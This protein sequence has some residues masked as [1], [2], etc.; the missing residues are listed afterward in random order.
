MIRP[1]N[2]A[3]VVF[4]DAGDGDL[5][6]APSRRAFF[7]SVLGIPA[8]WATVK[9]VHG[10]VIERA[11]SPG[12]IGE[13]DGIWTTKANLPVAVFTA[14]CL[15]VVLAAEGAKGVAHAGWRGAAQDVV[16]ALFEEMAAAGFRPTSAAI[17]PGIGPCCFEV[18]DEVSARFPDSQ[19]STTW[20]TQSVDL[21]RHITAGLG[22]DDVWSAGLCTM[23]DPGWFSHRRD[24]TKSRMAAVAWI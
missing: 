6:G 18:G 3:G 7:S 20:G 15:G 4:S 19:S 14:D 22:I 11:R 21:A 12:L 10:S 17:G 24:H 1:P 16:G 23:H 2:R 8:E 13:A 5:R 9:Q